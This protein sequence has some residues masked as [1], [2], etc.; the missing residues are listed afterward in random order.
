MVKKQL[1]RDQLREYQ[2]NDRILSSYEIDSRLLLK[3]DNEAGIKSGIPSLDNAISR[4][5]F[6]DLVVISGPTGNG[7]TLFAQTL[8]KYFD[9]KEQQ[10]TW[11]SY[12]MT[13]ERF[14][15]SFYQL[16]NFYAPGA[17]VQ[18][19]MDWF[20][21]RCVEAYEKFRSKIFI[22]DHLHYIIDM[23]KLRNPSLQIG[24]CVRRLKRFADTNRFLI[25]LICHVQKVSQDEEIRMH[26]IRDSSFVSQEADTVLMIQRLNENQGPNK[27]RIIVEKCRQTGVMYKRIDVVKRKG[28][29]VEE[30][31]F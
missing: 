23:F 29:L 5:L 24:A 15:R 13:E 10:A 1:T 30:T 6:G 2:G 31:P 16:P 19:S 12:E 25:F 27:A 18:A 21:E 28:V 7:K 9:S 17:Y 4:F 8:T 22:I 26:H 14:I 3:K 11:F 20:E